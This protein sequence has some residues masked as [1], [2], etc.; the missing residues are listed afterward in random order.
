MS[1]SVITEITN[2]DTTLNVEASVMQKRQ[3]E[4]RTKPIFC[5]KCNHL[6]TQQ[7]IVFF[8]GTGTEIHSFGDTGRVPGVRRHDCRYWGYIGGQTP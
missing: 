8:A 4:Q 2:T 6:G 5:V 1:S 7:T 3:P